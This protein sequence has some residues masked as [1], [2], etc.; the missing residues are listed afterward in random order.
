MAG[1]GVTRPS[2][3]VKNGGT[4]RGPGRQ[5]GLDRATESL[6]VLTPG[7]ADEPRGQ[8]SGHGQARREARTTAPAAPPPSVKPDPVTAIA[9]ALQAARRSPLLP[10]GQ[11]CPLARPCVPGRPG[12]GCS[13]VP[14]WRKGAVTFSGCP[15]HQ[16]KGHSAPDA[17]RRDLGGTEAQQREGQSRRKSAMNTWERGAGSTL[18]VPREPSWAFPRPVLVP[19]PPA[20]PP[21]P[22]LRGSS[23]GANQEIPFSCRPPPLPSR[24]T[25]ASPSSP[26]TGPSTPEHPA[27]ASAHPTELQLK[28]PVASAFLDPESRPVSS[29]FWSKGTPLTAGLRPP[30]CLSHGPWSSGCCEALPPAPGSLRL[31][32]GGS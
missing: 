10:S 3:R 31:W 26:A 20:F 7:R 27:R 4:G 19:E 14:C 5:R 32:V 29:H 17:G 21:C 30:V 11:A 22:L 28:S 12:P 9:I 15:S 6:H 1:P 2:D 24:T 8:H 25:L 13:C 16:E 18:L 23:L